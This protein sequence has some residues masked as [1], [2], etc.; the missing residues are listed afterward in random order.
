[1]MIEDLDFKKKLDLIKHKDYS[2]IHLAFE[3]KQISK[4]EWYLKF[5][6]IGNEQDNVR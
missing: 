3:Y 1:M 6:L 4:T 2:V 5:Q